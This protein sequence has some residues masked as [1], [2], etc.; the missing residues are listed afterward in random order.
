METSAPK[1]TTDDAAQAK[2][3]LEA[4]AI[5]LGREVNV[6]V[7]RAALR[8]KDGDASAS[9]QSQEEESDDFYEF[10]E[11]DYA[12]MLASKKPE[13]FLK[14][15]KIR[16]AEEAAR[17]TRLTKS[18]IRVQF[19]DNYIV[20]AKFQP[21]DSLLTLIDLLKKVISRV[22]VPFDLYTTPPK[23]TLQ[24]MKKDFYSL[25]LVPGALVYFSYNLSK[26]FSEEEQSRILSTPYLQSDVMA[27]KDLHLSIAP[28]TRTES[29]GNTPA[30]FNQQR[31]EQQ[32]NKR[33]GKLGLKPKWMKL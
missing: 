7:R 22:D 33:P 3:L 18:I 8:E 2:A 32:S 5:H 15:K 31:M 12:R 20:E 25:G 16:D 10:T 14:T 21:S 28:V 6:S 26:G 1:C 13:T 4:A 19:P 27:L 9:I 11:E 29:P 30:A 24:D 23:Q 17:R